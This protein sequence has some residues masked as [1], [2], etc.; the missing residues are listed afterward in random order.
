[1]MS[2]IFDHLN[3]MMRVFCARY[4]GVYLMRFDLYWYFASL[5]LLLMYKTVEDNSYFQKESCENML[6]LPLQGWQWLYNAALCSFHL[7]SFPV[8]LKV[9]LIRF[10][11][12]DFLSALCKNSIQMRGRCLNALYLSDSFVCVKATLF[13]ATMTAKKEKGICPLIHQAF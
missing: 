8:A 2:G 5:R 10:F 12:D 3:Q 6:A 13:T 1:M 4:G 7:I 11:R 9:V